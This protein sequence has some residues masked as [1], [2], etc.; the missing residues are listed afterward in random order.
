MRTKTLAA[1]LL[2]S[3]SLCSSAFAQPAKPAPAKPAAAPPP[4]PEPPPAPPVPAGPPPLSESLTGDAKAEYESGK[5]L[6]ADGDNAG[7]AIKFKSAYEKSNDPRL[8]WNMAA[9]E[10]NLRRYSRALKQLSQYL[11]EGG[12]KLT[13]QDR[14]E[15]AELIKVMEP[16]T[17][18][19]KINATEPGAEVYI[20]DELLGTTPVE[21]AVV[22]LGMRKIRVQKADFEEV[23]KDIAVGGA[24]EVAVDVPLVKIVHEGRLNVRTQTDASIS[25]DGKVVGAGSW[26]GSLASG[27]HLI[28][29]TAPKRM[30]YQS[31]VYL[32]DKETRDLDVTLDKEPSKGVPTWMWIAGGVVLA[33]GITTASVLMFGGGESTYEGP[34]G[35][36]TGVGHSP[37]GVAELSRFR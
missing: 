30:P 13:D 31:E 37:G 3:L 12:S 27:G 26:S 17:A 33:G 14:A 2:V 28:R 4:A 25:I 36:L 10:K 1:S 23:T 32:Q 8:L 21:P 18:K 15:A 6:F 5:L 35:N 22:D 9:C 19:L 7:A 24:A 11:T 34:R 20:D 29:V 16:F